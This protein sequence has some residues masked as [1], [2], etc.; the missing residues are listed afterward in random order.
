MSEPRIEKLPLSKVTADERLQPR[1]R[2]DEA[3]VEEYA[4][5]YRSGAPLPRPVVFRDEAGKNWLADGFQRLSAMG[6]AKFTTAEFEVRDG[7]F[8][9]AKLFAAAANQGHGLRRTN[10]DKQRAVRFALEVRPQWSDRQIANHCGVHAET[11]GDIRAEIAASTE[12]SRESMSVSDIDSPA[13]EG[14]SALGPGHR[15]VRPKKAE[16]AKAVARILKDDPERED[17]PVAEEVGCKPELVARLRKKLIEEGHIA[18]PAAVRTREQAEADRKTEEI[19]KA[20]KTDPERFG[21][22][23]ERLKAGAPVEKVH[24][25]LRKREKEGTVKKNVLLDADD[26]P[27]P[28][29][30]R[31]LFGSKFLTDLAQLVESLVR[32]GVEKVYPR[33]SDNGHRF[34]FLLVGK[35]L[36]A[37][38]SAKADLVLAHSHLNE[39]KPHAVCPRCKGD[40]SARDDSPAC[41]ACRST[42]YVPKWRQAELK[43]GAE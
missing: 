22:L 37:L 33:V 3:V 7:D 36:K 43:G 34:K 16:H 6:L 28:D 20:A 35:V 8:A 41:R 30:L 13:D 1:A 24:K 10:E 17:G 2:Q 26:N 14:E 42:G 18:A 25:E 15:G 4:D 21:D 39:S 23:A 5:A 32:D 38:E 12:A 27:V 31:D 9:D 19:R 11:V 40:S 29:H